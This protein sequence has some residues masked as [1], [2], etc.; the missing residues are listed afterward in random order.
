MLKRAFLVLALVGLLA[1]CQSAEERA[2][3]HYQSAV[4]L[5]QKGDVDRG[6]V[7]LR[8][9]FKLNGKHHDARA[10]YART[11]RERGNVKEAYGQYLRLSEQYPGDAEASLALTEL[12]LQSGQGDAARRFA[13]ALREGAGGATLSPRAEAAL[14]AVEYAE[15]AAK[16]DQKTMAAAAGTAARLI[17][18][19]PGLYFA[20]QTL[21]SQDVATQDWSAASAQVSAG[22]AELTA[23]GAPISAEARIALRRF[24]DTRL[25][26]LDRLGD[27]PGLEATLKEMIARFPDEASIEATLVRWYVGE[28]RIDEAEGWLRD[29]VG[30]AGRDPE[31]RMTLIR[32]LSQLRSPEAA[33]AELDKTL[34]ADPVPEDVAA[35]KAALRGLRASF[36]YQLRDP[37][38]AV[39]DMRTILDEGAADGT[40]A[41][42][43]DRLRIS[44]AKMEDGQGNRVGARAL[45]ETVLD[46]DATNVEALKLKAGWLIDDDKTGDALVALRA[47]LGQAPRDADAMTLMARAYDREGNRDLMVDMLSRAVEASNGAPEES[48]R[49]ARFLLGD[50]KLRGAEDV[51]IDALRLAPS[52]LQ[53]LAQLGQTHVAMEDWPRAEQD[54]ARLRQ[55][56]PEQMRA[57]AD[58]LQARVFAGQRRTDDLTAFLEKRAAEGSDPLAAEAAVIRANLIAGNVS[59]ALERSRSLI[60]AAPDNPAAMFVRAS[61]LG[62]AGQTAEAVTLLERVVAAAPDQVQG[63]TT[64][65]ALL[66]R[67]GDLDR[68]GAVLDRGMAALPDN[69]QIEYAK[70]GYL[71]RRGDLEGAIALYEK[72]YAANSNQ[73]VIANNL[74]SL[75]TTARDD[76]DSL[77]RAYVVARRL[78]G[79]D[80]PAFQD[81]YGWIVF[82]RGDIGEAVAA[83]EPAARGL[84]ENALVQYHLGRVYATQ[85]EKDRARAQYDKA[86]QLIGTGNDTPLEA[87]LTAARAA[88]DSAAAGGAGAASP[89][90]AGTAGQ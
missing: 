35:N 17:A 46:R 29:R 21:I 11:M 86:L 26:V 75:L 82:R 69:P 65:G 61:V 73:V 76:G 85:G 37:K 52:N 54:I 62:L 90:A 84:P 81:T 3:E 1:A 33:L 6:L 70:A 28:G 45:I 71:E 27:K 78:R 15:A 49:Y 53:L 79:L 18:A 40:P 56:A 36:A 14:S 42:Q 12:A 2:E 83:L 55:L 13:K 41:D 23:T 47:A 30:R 25:A 77:E 50:H 74:A 48:L 58:E 31:P 80:N 8:N 68:A 16:R 19:D 7:E 10:L 24:Y 89:A 22:I 38:Q 87:E 51:L 64:L 72:M 60:E 34:A 88:L 20:R 5:M 44:L 4:A 43:L 63:W 39:A 59:A 9:V 66:I 32:F 67:D 57:V